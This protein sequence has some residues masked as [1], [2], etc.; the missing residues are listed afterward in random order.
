MT[1]HL[2]LARM[3]TLVAAMRQLQVNTPM[4]LAQYML[5][6]TV[7]GIARTWQSL[8]NIV[9]LPS[10]ALRLN[11][12]AAGSHRYEKDGMA[13][14]VADL[15]R[16]SIRMLGLSMLMG[17]PM[18]ALLSLLPDRYDLHGD[19]IPYLVLFIVFN[20]LAN[21]NSIL[22]T[23]YYSSGQT[24]ALVKR[25][26]IGLSISLILTP[27]LIGQ[28]G[29]LGIPIVQIVT[30]T[31]ILVITIRFLRDTILKETP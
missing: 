30:S 8:A 26:I 21:T 12:M 13:P 31:V 7:L 14:L 9:T 11:V 15:R 29:G 28:I 1:G 19:G 23:A 16:I 22:T 24:G 27:I 5:G 4:L 17:L 2:T 18:I 6:E 20:L 10:N 3:A 25:A